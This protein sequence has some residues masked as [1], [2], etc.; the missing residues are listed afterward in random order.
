MS[1]CKGVREVGFFDCAGGGQ[2]MVEGNFAYIGHITGPDGTTIADVSDPKH[3]RKVAE[4]RL[5]DVGIHSH[6]AR[7]A[8]GV[9]L[10]NYEIDPAVKVPAL[11]N[12]SGKGGLG[13]FDV[14]DPARP[15]LI[16]VWRCEGTGIHRFTFD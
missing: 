4:L 6:K 13:I 12:L 5:E 14:S 9:M 1:V 8:N 16:T 15:K 10:V 7:A 2:V 11:H 3:P